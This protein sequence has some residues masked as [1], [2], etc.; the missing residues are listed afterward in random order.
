[1]MPACPCGGKGVSKGARP[2]VGGSRVKGIRYGFCLSAGPK[3][4]AFSLI[5]SEER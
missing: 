5:M 1:M 3:N 2:G 4:G